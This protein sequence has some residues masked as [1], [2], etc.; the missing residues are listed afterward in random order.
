MTFQR[1]EPQCQ[2]F[3]AHLGRAFIVEATLQVGSN[4]RLHCQSWFDIPATELFAPAGSSGRTFASYL[5]SAGRIEAIWFPFTTHPWLK[6]WSVSP[7]QPLFSRE[8]TAPYNYPFSDSISQ[9][10][11]DVVEQILSGDPSA[12]TQL[13][14]LQFDIVAAG[15]VLTFSFDLWGWSKKCTA[16]HQADHAARDR[17]RL[18]GADESI[19][20]AA[21]AA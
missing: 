16:L 21:C 14:P 9:E 5:D 18:R 3:L 8:V 20:R 15:L 17:E 6:V 10:V 13:G 19:Q 7:S 2:A 1:T 4:Q 11:V 12:A